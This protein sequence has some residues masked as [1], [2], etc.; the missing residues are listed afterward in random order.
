MKLATLA[1][2]VFHPS[3]AVV[4]VFMGAT[5]PAIAQAG[6]E[7]GLVIAVDAGKNTLV[8]ETRAG[9]KQVPVA[10]AATIRGDHGEVLKLADLNPG[11]AIA[12][13]TGSET[14]TS[15][16]VAREFWAVPSGR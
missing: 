1:R 16:H 2:L 13:T 7:A 9:L 8:L 12:Y 3:C 14:A 6:P 15:L 5:T 10:V 11:D 4:L